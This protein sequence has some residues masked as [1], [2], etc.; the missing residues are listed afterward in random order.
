M[1]VVH[2]INLERLM[3]LCDDDRTEAHE[4]LEL[5]LENAEGLI[6][7]MTSALDRSELTEIKR[8]AHQLRGSAGNVGADEVATL[9]EH[10]ERSIEGDAAA[11]GAHIDDIR[12]AL[13]R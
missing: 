7:Q 5:T 4:L 11:I 2:P 3:F 10:I 9:A 12:N 6:A 1:S 13:E 8:A